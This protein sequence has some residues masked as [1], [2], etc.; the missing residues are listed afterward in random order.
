M[1]DSRRDLVLANHILA[2]EGILDAFGHV[3]VR[4]PDDPKRF[5]L[6]WARAPELIE[7]DDL[8]EFDAEGEP[9]NPD[10]RFPYLERY[11]HA[12]IY[13]HRPDVMAVCHNHTESILPF[14]ISKTVRLRPVIH[15]AAVMGEEVPVWDIATEFGSETN[16]LVVNM[17]QGRSLARA[18]G[19]ATVALMRGHG[20]VVTGPSIPAVVSACLNVDKNARV[21]MQA[22]RLG[23]YIPLAPGEV[24]RPSVA[25]GRSVVPDRG[26]EA[27]VR[28]VTDPA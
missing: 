10:G 12:A 14:S 16:L 20:S 21:Q 5:I 6:S 17:Q 27:Y 9:I 15:T 18:L 28:R 3:S 11:I 23:E 4:H 22:M 26:W 8:L 25:P 7:P 1:D 13:E 24:A 2:R 19:Q